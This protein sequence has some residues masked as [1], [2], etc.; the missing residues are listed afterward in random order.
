MLSIVRKKLT[1]A[2]SAQKKVTRASVSEE[3]S[4]AEDTN[5]SYEERILTHRFP[6]EHD[7]LED[8]QVTLLMLNG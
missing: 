3:K 2:I 6:S 4:V 5:E 7:I 1:A 8:V